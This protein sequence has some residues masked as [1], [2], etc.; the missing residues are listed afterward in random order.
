MPLTSALA[1]TTVSGVLM[2]VYSVCDVFEIIFIKRHIKVI[3]KEIEKE[4]EKVE[5]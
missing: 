3:E 1:L 4:I 5:E 2:L